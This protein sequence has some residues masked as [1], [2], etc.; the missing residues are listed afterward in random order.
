MMS[1]NVSNGGRSFNRRYLV[2]YVVVSSRPR[3]RFYAIVGERKLELAREMEKMGI[4]K[5]LQ[6]VE[7]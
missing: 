1:V 4:F 3:Q 6:V 5:I 2:E 7:V